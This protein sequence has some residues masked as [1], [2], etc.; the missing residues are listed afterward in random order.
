MDCS[1]LDKVFDEKVRPVTEELATGKRIRTCQ[2]EEVR[3]GTSKELALRS[4]FSGCE[5]VKR[6]GR[7]AGA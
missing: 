1:I 7:A 4:G 2:R 3:V 5:G 6:L